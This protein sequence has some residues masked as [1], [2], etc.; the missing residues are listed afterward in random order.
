MWQSIQVR[1]KPLT[2]ALGGSDSGVKRGAG[3]ISAALMVIGSGIGMLLPVGKKRKPTA[4][5]KKTKVSPQITG[6]SSDL[7]V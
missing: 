5:A 7:V 4:V 1:S 6:R 2:M 3:L